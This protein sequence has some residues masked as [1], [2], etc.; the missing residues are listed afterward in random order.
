MNNKNITIRKADFYKDEMPICKLIKNENVYKISKNDEY[1]YITE[2][3]EHENIDKREHDKMMNFINYLK[4]NKI[5]MTSSRDYDKFEKYI[6]NGDSKYLNK[7]QK[8]IVSNYEDSKKRELRISPETLQIL[9]HIDVEQLRNTLLIMGTA[10][11][12][13]S[14]FAASYVYMFHYYFKDS[15]IFY[16]SEKPIESD[17]AYSK[18]INYIT[19]LKKEDILTM[20]ENEE[21]PYKYF[22]DQNTRQSLVIL[23]DIEIY[24]NDPVMSGPLEKLKNSILT[25]GRSSG[26]SLIQI[27]HQMTNRTGS[28]L[29]LDLFES[30]MIVIFPKYVFPSTLSY[31]LLKKLNLPKETAARISRMHTRACVILLRKGVVVGDHDIF[32]I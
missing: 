16:F 28:N 32:F 6:I 7:E 4:D 9:P 10:G 29:S 26:I 21:S 15:K 24:K 14:Y 8:M 19:P 23:D 2:E 12:G 31:F 27:V 5:N 13:K 1:I 25:V 22:A 20:T 11:S 3:E 17:P 30:N 18:V